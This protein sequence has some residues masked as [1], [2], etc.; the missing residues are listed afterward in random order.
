MANKTIKI[1]ESQ[2]KSVIKQAIQ[3]SWLWADKNDMDMGDATANKMTETDF[4]YI[5]SE[6]SRGIL[7]ERTLQYPKIGDY[8]VVPDMGSMVHC[9]DS[10]KNFGF[11]RYMLM[12]FSKDRTYCLMQRE[13]NEKYFFAE[14]V[15]APELG[16]KRTKWVPV[17]TSNIPTM[18][19]QDAQRRLRE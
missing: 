14:I 4:K 18:I 3:E 15:D 16:E 10:L 19:F 6:V 2:L 9:S 8:T 5:V 13:D 12:Y 17:P 11:Y 7:K 1:T